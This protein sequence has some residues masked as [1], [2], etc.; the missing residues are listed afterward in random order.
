[1]VDKNNVYDIIKPEL[2]KTNAHENHRSKNQA[3][4]NFY[5]HIGGRS[6]AHIPR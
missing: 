1:M 3:I 6:Y 5:H 4:T 2:T